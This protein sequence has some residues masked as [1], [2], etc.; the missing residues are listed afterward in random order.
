M[1]AST[2]KHADTIA[3]IATPP[4]RG[5]IGVVRVS[6]SRALAIGKAILGVTPAPRTAAYERFYDAH[7]RIIDDGIALFFPAPRSSTGESVL[8]LQGHGGPVVLDMVLKRALSLGARLARPGE[9]S[10]RAFL[11]GKLDLAQAEAVADLIESGTEQAARSAA[12]SKQGAFSTAIQELVDELIDL[13]GFVE[14][15]LDFSEEDLEFPGE[16]AVNARLQTLQH[17]L[18]MVHEQARQGALMREGVTLVIAG[19]PNVGKSSLLNRLAG[20]DLAIVTH[21]PGTTRDVVRQD[22]QI[23]GM[24]LRVIDTAGLRESV[25]PI[26]LEGIRRARIEIETGDLILLVVDARCGLRSDTQE[27]LEQLPGRAPLLTVW[28]KI[29]LCDVPPGRREGIVYVSALTGAG[30]GALTHAVKDYMGFKASPE[31]VFLA[32]RRHLVA[33]ETAAQALV[34]ANGVARSG[35][36]GELLAEELRAAQQALSEITGAFTSEDLLGQIFSNFCIGK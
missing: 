8:E 26:E 24:P 14:A 21:L 1:Y 28:N 15:T 10:E 27:I 12:R 34:R 29:D 18:D 5:G 30:F 13:R 9:F 11:N 7:G 20:S 35:S 25:D 16:P 6:G 22:I 31:G 36:Y 2:I 19:R 32:R 33:L 3:A 17:Q 4:G 23:D